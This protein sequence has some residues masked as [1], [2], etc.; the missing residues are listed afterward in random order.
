MKRGKNGFTLVEL[1]VVVGILIALVA[2]LLPLVFNALERAKVGRAAIDVFETI[3]A[4]L[5]HLNDT[6]NFPVVVSDLA[7][8]PCGANRP[9]CVVCNLYRYTSLITCDI[10]G[11]RTCNDEEPEWLR[12]PT[13]AGPYF[14]REIAMSPWAFEYY[15][16]VTPCISPPGLNV[17]MSRFFMRGVSLGLWKLPDPE[18]RVRVARSLDRILDGDLSPLAGRVRYFQIV[19]G[20]Q[21]NV[22]Y[23]CIGM[24]KQTP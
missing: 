3:N 10:N 24:G 8:F 21:L 16:C 12:P 13:W 19:N 18:A 9:N 5:L 22:D 11:S 17:N 23:L 14:E 20:G 6:G 1:L 15:Y 7:G 4:T 2:V